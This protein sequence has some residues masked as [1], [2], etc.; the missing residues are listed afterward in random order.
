MTLRT[1]YNSKVIAAALLFAITLAA[2]ISLYSTLVSCR[3][4]PFPYDSAGHAYEGL[5]IAED[6]RTGDIISFLAD[7]YR[8]SFWPFFHSW[9]LAPAFILFGNT[10]AVAR[11]VS[12][13]CFVLFV[14]TI[15]LM[16]MEM[17]HAHG[18]WVG[19]VAAYFALTSLPMLVLSVMSMSEIPGLLMT[20]LT[21]L[22]YLKALKQNKTYLFC[23]TSILTAL[24]FFTKWHHGVFAA[25]AVFLTQIVHS[26]RLLSRTNGTL[27]FPFLAIAAAWFIYPPHI[28]SFYHHST[29]QPHFYK[30]LS[31][32]NWLFYPKGFLNVYH[33]SPLIAIVVLLSFLYSFKRLKEPAIMLL[34]IHVLVGIVVMT[35]K[36][37]NRYRYII[38]LVPSVWL[39]ASM[40]LVNICHRFGCNIRK[41]KL[42]L[43][44]VLIIM[45]A[46]FLTT[47]LSVA[48]VYRKYP[49]S[50]VKYNFYCDDRPEKAYKFISE[51]VAGH[52]DIAVFGTWDHYNSLKSTTVSWN[53]AVA[54]QKDLTATYDKK[55]KAQHYFFQVLRN[56]DLRSYREFIHF[57]ENKDLKVYEYH[58]L[59]FM[60]TVDSQSYEKYRERTKL[61]PFSDN[62]V[63]PNSIS[64]NITCLI[65]ICTE[66]EPDLNYFTGHFLSKQD[67]WSEFRRKRFPDLDTTV[68][69]YRRSSA[70]L[71][72]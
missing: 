41:N 53:I 45:F 29:F 26:R 8:Q 52:N 63:D 22:C 4:I 2:S 62:I 38:T 59:S 15:Y 1:T 20:F 71:P 40:Q 61:N 27:L 13:F 55:R 60:K 39:L 56:W 67:D 11:G 17:S 70:H 24:T 9:L 37:D 33:S 36:L 42:T 23:C 43:A 5:R 57:L 7:T 25:A 21:F 65:T 50:L 32:D 16:G 30:F 48:A 35:I 12:L 44:S 19:I 34:V 6:I 72:T 54:R 69:I 14:L 46:V 47:S 68:T 18:H 64:D 51:N 31:G 28:V 3:N 58:L 49:K 66:K 10:Y